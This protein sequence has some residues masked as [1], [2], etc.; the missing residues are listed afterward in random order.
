MIR[1]NDGKAV[2][3]ATEATAKSL[4]SM[5]SNPTM[6][7]ALDV[8]LSAMNTISKLSGVGPATASLVLAVYSPRIPFF[9]DE[10]WAWLFPEKAGGKLKYDRKEY[11][12]LFCKCWEVR[13]RAGKGVDMVAL[14]KASFVL[15]HIDLVPENHLGPLT[16]EG[17]T[18]KDTGLKN[19]SKQLDEK[20][21]PDK[22]HVTGSSKA[23]NK[24]TAPKVG[25]AQESTPDE[26]TR[27]SKRSKK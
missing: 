10:L 20:I 27:R 4:A 18:E 21:Q 19:A 2:L 8:T 23:H 11:E 16:R 15:Q 1:K 22:S 12:M 3:E 9:Q 26:G 13:E 24:R 17:K 6:S 7:Q 25:A 5:P 14:E